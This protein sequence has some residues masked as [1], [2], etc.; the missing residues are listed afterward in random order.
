MTDLGTVFA[1]LGAFFAALG[2]LVLIT[3]RYRDRVD[4]RIESA[5]IDGE[6]LALTVRNRGGRADVVRVM[7][8]PGSGCAGEAASSGQIPMP[9]RHTREV[10]LH[11]LL[12]QRDC[13]PGATSLRLLGADGHPWQTY[14]LSPAIRD[15]LREGSPPG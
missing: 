9:A 12:L 11:R 10:H 1:G 6:T 2:V 5:R 15:W 8:A 14:K 4:N 13:P 3:F 7:F